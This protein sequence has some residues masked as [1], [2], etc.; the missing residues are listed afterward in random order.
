MKH[1]LTILSPLLALILSLPV[2]GVSFA[3]KQVVV[4]P[5]AV[6]DLGSGGFDE[7]SD[8]VFGLSIVPLASGD[9]VV[10][11][12]TL[13]V[14]GS[15]VV[16]VNASGFFDYSGGAGSTGRCELTKGITIDVLYGKTV[17]YVDGEFGDEENIAL[18]RG[19][20]VSGRGSNT[21]NLVCDKLCGFRRP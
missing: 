21:Y 20:N 16:I 6:D 18:T 4:I 2:P 9:T 12:V 8:A 13:K 1:R 17:I 7:E 15:G 3:D 19:F 10:R 14:R 11:S 5:L